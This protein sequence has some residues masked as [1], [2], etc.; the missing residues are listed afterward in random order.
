MVKCHIFGV[1]VQRLQ[2]MNWL[3]DHFLW[4]TRR[5]K[6]LWFPCWEHAYQIID[7]IDLSFLIRLNLT[8]STY[9]YTVWVLMNVVYQPQHCELLAL[10]PRKY[11]SLSFFLI[12][13]LGY[14]FHRCVH[15]ICSTLL[16][17]IRWI[18]FKHLY[19][20]IR[21]HWCD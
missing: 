1:V 17:K 14:S 20:L 18:N 2:I 5:T 3:K 19:K 21:K 10:L 11:L 9:E 13:Q 16:T 12:G 8:I 6:T 4:S 15:F 7:F